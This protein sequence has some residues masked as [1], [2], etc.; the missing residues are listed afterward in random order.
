MGP[1]SDSFLRSFPQALFSLNAKIENT[2]PS[3][4]Y[5]FFNPLSVIESSARFCAEPLTGPSLRLPKVRSFFSRT[6][7]GLLTAP[8]FFFC[9]LD[10]RSFRSGLR[11]AF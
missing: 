2:R 3:S 4:T 7:S 5:R 1:T 6:G 9:K 11:L 10:L 8:S